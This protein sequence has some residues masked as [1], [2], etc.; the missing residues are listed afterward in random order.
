MPR[1]I[2]LALIE[3]LRPFDMA[4]GKYEHGVY[5][6]GWQ[7]KDS[8]VVKV[9]DMMERH[10]QDAVKL[11][12]TLRQDYLGR[13]GM[14]PPNAW[15]EQPDIQSR[16]RSTLEREWGIVFRKAKGAWA[17]LAEK[18]NVKQAELFSF[19]VDTKNTLTAVLAKQAEHDKRLAQHDRRIAALERGDRTLK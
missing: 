18:V 7:V 12:V 2:G 4:G 16:I 6:K 11:E 8:K 1:D 5:T 10:G 17:M 14:F 15:E 19:M 3:E 13:A 9:Y